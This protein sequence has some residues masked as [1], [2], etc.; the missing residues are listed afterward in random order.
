MIIC[1]EMINSLSKSSLKDASLQC[2]CIS[3]SW[4]RPPRSG[5]PVV[6]NRNGTQTPVTEPR[7][8]LSPVLTRIDEVTVCPFLLSNQGFW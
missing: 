2:E 7:S 8:I 6:K 3:T 1:L 5:E 4:L